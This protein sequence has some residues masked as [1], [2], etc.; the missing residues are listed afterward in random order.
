MSELTRRRFLEAGLGVT[1]G[2]LLLPTLATPTEA[3]GELGSYGEFVQRPTPLP[4]PA[5]M[6]LARLRAGS[7]DSRRTSIPAAN[8][9]QPKTTS[10][11]HIIAPTRRTAPRSRRR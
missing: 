8:F 3:S 11:G 6:P 7:G 2:G 10:W 1:A 4:T 5:E 9:A